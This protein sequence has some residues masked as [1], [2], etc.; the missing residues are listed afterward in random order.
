MEDESVTD[1]S[2]FAFSDKTIRRGF[3]RKVF[4]ILMVQLLVTFGIVCLFLFCEPVQ[5]YSQQNQWVYIL[6]IVIT[7]VCMIVLACCGEVRRKFP[8]NFIFLGI[9]TVCEGYL[10]GSVC[11]MYEVE[12]VLM[13]IGITVFITFGLV[14]FAMQTKLD[15]T[16]LSGALLVMLLALFCFGI[17][18]MLFQDRILNIVYASL[19][20]L[21][22]GFYLV[23]DVQMMMGGN[24]K[25]SIS[26]EEYIFAALNIYLDVINLFMYILAIVGNARN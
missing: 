10:I 13:A 17:L 11:A 9:F 22:F 26:P 23:F 15:F 16:G 5:Q 24:H 2:E 20:A 8:T 7:F 4:A 14:V 21:L 1:F 12:E 25:F 19:G 3:I 18:A 6:A